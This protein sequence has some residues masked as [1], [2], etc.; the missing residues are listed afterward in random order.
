V[1]GLQTTQAP[2]AGVGRLGGDGLLD[3]EMAD[4]RVV[5][6]GHFGVGVVHA[7]SRHRAD[8]TPGNSMFDC[9]EH[10]QTSPTTTSSSLIVFLPLT[11]SRAGAPGLSGCR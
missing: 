9:P 1:A 7:D 4:E 6:G 8:P 11:V 5:G 3:F 2:R 10:T